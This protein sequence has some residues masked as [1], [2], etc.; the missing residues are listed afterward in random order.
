MKLNAASCTDAGKERDINEDRVW[1]QIFT[2]SEGVSRGLFIVCD[3]MGGHLG[4]ECASHWAVETVK[5][6]L[7]DLFSVRDPRATVHLSEEGLEAGRDDLRTRQTEASLFEVRLQQAVQRANQV[8]FTYAQ[9]K[10]DKAG[11]AGTTITMALISDVYGIFANVGDS[12]TYL[13]REGKLRQVTRDHSLV[14]RMLELGQ[15]S[16][17]E[18]YSHPQRNVIYRSL[19][20][21]RDVQVDTFVEILQPGDWLL[22]CSDGLWEMVQDEAAIAEMLVSAGS[23]EKACAQLVEAAN[24]A[25]GED[26]I[27]VVV[28]QID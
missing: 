17:Q 18:V 27:G 1:S 14:A 4:G 23:P 13:Y 7:A 20:Q 10:P 24:R 26:N 21:K 28:V 2:P 6:E 15:I 12:R 9:N 22:L 8:V 25:G 19:G 11:D 5:H 16:P 3:G